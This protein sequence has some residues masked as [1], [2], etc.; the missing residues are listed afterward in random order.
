MSDDGPRLETRDAQ[1]AATVLGEIDAAD[2]GLSALHAVAETSGTFSDYCAGTDHAVGEAAYT[3]ID[4]AETTL[5]TDVAA[6]L[7]LTVAFSD[8]DGD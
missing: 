7:G 5:A 6:R 8:M 1:L 2:A 3:R 4:A